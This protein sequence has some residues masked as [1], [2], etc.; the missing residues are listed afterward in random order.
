MYLPIPTAK[1][2]IDR[3]FVLNRIRACIE[4]GFILHPIA[5][6]HY[7]RINRQYPL[8][9]KPFLGLGVILGS[10]S[11]GEKREPDLPNLFVNPADRTSKDVIEKSMGHLKSYTRVHFAP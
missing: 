3:L 8:D 10:R 7:S 11:Y 5:L 1:V 9:F 4:A 6:G 2:P